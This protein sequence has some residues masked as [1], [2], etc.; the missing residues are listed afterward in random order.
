[1]PISAE[2]LARDLVV[3][4]LTDPAA[5]PHAVQLVLDRAV[6]ALADR[7][8]CEVR[9]WRGDRVVTVADN[10]D[11]L[12]YHPDDVTRDARYTRYV[13]DRRML[14][15]HS[16]ASV[17]SALRA[18]AADPVD[19]VLLVCP[20]VVYRRDVID[21]LHSGTPHQ[22]DL[23][24][25]TR[26]G[27]ADLDG[28]IEA[29]LGGL[30][31]GWE[32]RTEPRVHP[33]TV[34]GRQVDVLRAGEWV[35][36]AE[37]GLAG[38][39]VLARAGLAGWSGLA[40]GMGLD[41]MLMLIKGITDIRVLRSAE[42][43]VVAQLAD[44]APYRPVSAMPAI[45]RDLSVAVDGDVV[46]EEL[47]DRVREALG[48][49][50]DCVETVEMLASTPCAELPP[51]AL[52]RLGARVDQRNVLLTVVLRRLD[53]TLTDAEANR[54]RDRVY[55]ALHQGTVHQWAART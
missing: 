48:E 51:R 20:G 2:Q 50:A 21:R 25:I 46:A 19:D 41:R 24:R 16:T 53:R 37:C 29:L 54:L 11:N 34:A 27:T 45:R 49:D 8:G 55:A 33:Y 3:R 10:Y 31:P 42:P 23:W 7:W 12:G 5:G 43:A 4:D 40:L 13:D 26:H 9:W 15:S 39:P 52:E 32:Y 1:M 17:P 36:V 38:P 35:E 18:L 28:M 6:G 30:L 47:G 14:R 44:L 22:V